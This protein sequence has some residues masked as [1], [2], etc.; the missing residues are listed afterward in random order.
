MREWFYDKVVYNDCCDL[1]DHEVN[2]KGNAICFLCPC[3]CQDLIR[4][5]IESISEPC[6]NFSLA[7]NKISIS[8]SIRLTSGCKSHFN[9]ITNKV[10]W[11]EA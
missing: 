3:G 1:N 7:D 8:P 6:W 9:I 11:L 2:I 10:I 4:L 5:V